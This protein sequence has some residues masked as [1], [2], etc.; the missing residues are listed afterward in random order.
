MPGTP[1][2]DIR[3]KEHNEE[4]AEHDDH[5]EAEDDGMKDGEVGEQM[6]M[7]LIA[8]AQPIAIKMIEEDLEHGALAMVD[9]HW[10][11]ITDKDH[12]NVEIEPSA[13]P[14]ATETSDQD[15]TEGW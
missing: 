5:R 11:A 8:A 3:Y 2:R 10:D 6:D 9:V 15:I 12:L 1:L 7:E 4:T 13:Q 14:N